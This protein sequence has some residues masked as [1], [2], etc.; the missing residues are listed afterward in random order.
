VTDT[1]ATDM[2]DL[3]LVGTSEDRRHV[4]LADADT[5]EQFRVAADDSL[6]AALRG[7]RTGPGQLESQMDSALRPRDIQARIRGGAT[8]DEVAEVAQVPVERIMGYAIPVLAE[9]EHIAERA[10]TASVRR[11]HTEGPTR[12]LGDTVAAQLRTQEIDPGSV[13]WDSW[14]RDD[15][16]WVV[17]VAADDSDVAHY[18]YDAAG[19][20]VVADDDAARRLIADEPATE[21]P[22]TMAVAAALQAPAGTVPVEPPDWTAQQRAEP[23]SR[24]ERPVQAE[25]DEVAEVAAHDL[26][27]DEADGQAEVGAVSRLRRRRT[28]HQVPNPVPDPLPLDELAAEPATDGDAAD[29]AGGEPAASQTPAKPEPRKRRDRRRA[30]VPSW[31][32]I[33]FGGGKSD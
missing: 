19:R 9:R 7:D 24:S 5:G 31:D 28:L 18:V 1:E 6:R 29:E 14:R 17:T 32:E 33:M 10:R 23:V 21:D 16:R 4:V 8:P 30:S 20:Y 25:P 26:R 11:R 15:G 22:S 27:D 3:K 2:R 12:L 13:R